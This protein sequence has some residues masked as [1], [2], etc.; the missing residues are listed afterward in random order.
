MIRAVLELITHLAGQC[1][2]SLRRLCPAVGVSRSNVI[3][4]RRQAG[5]GG[6]APVLQHPGPRKM[7]VADI[8]AATRDI[9]ML[10]HGLHRSR[11]SAALYAKYAGSLSRRELDGMI[12]AAR[13]DTNREQHDHMRRVT[14]NAS[15]VAWSMD[16]TEYGKV[17]SCARKPVIHHVEDLGSKYTLPPF[18][19]TLPVG[20]EVAGNLLHQFNLHGAPLFVKRD[21][22]GNL[23]HSAVEE[24]LAEYVVLPLNSPVCYPPYNGAVE[25]AQGE[26]KRELWNQTAGVRWQDAAALDPY[27]RAAAQE[28][29][30]RP[31][32]CLG[33]KTPCQVFFNNRVTF[34]K[35]ERKAIYGWITERRNDIINGEDAVSRETAWRIAAEQWLVKHGFITRSINKQVLPNFQTKWFH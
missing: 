1:G 12:E 22:A 16:D 35:T 34:S 33:E 5:R 14:W 9:R 2:I 28:L 27:A 26:L 10:G 32:P 8:A 4:W 29:N 31:K 6:G 18:C 30:H 11:G 13:K 15:G 7:E 20:E 25:E 19:G 21:N 24:V 17:D 23:N 3:R